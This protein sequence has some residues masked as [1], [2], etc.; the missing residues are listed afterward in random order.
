MSRSEEEDEEK[1]LVFTD[2]FRVKALALLS[3]TVMREGMS[4]CEV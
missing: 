1:L 3:G 2:F 4:G